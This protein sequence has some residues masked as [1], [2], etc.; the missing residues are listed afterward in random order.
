MHGILGASDPDQRRITWPVEVDRDGTQLDPEA[1]WD[2]GV[3]EAGRA[4]TE[5]TV[6]RG[7]A[8]NR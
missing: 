7:R 3:E 2:A 4:G 5:L 6:A 1:V 8:A